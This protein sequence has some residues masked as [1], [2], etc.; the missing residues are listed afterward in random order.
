M[1][2]KAA[3]NETWSDGIQNSI[4]LP[5]DPVYVKV[6]ELV[7][8]VGFS[9]TSMAVMLARHAD[10]ACTACSVTIHSTYFAIELFFEIEAKKLIFATIDLGIFI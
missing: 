7:D 10:Y 6:V 5:I 1:K 9:I 2:Q 8:S 3:G 4:S